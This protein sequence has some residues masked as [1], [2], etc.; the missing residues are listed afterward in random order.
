MRTAQGMEQSSAS[1]TARETVG[2][3]FRLFMAETRR[4]VQQA[5]PRETGETCETHKEKKGTKQEE[6]LERKRARAPKKGRGRQR[7]KTLEERPGKGTGTLKAKE[8]TRV[9]GE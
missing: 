8:E 1:K 3:R 6:A 9:T 2:G 5:L 7:Q 4:R